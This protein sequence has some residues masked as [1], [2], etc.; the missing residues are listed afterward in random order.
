MLANFSQVKVSTDFDELVFFLGHVQEAARNFAELGDRLRTA[1]SRN[2]TPSILKHEINTVFAVQAGDLLCQCWRRGMLSVYR[3]H[4]YMLE[5]DEPRIRYVFSWFTFI[6]WHLAPMFKTRFRDDWKSEFA[7]EMDQ[8]KGQ[9]YHS[10][11][12]YQSVASD[13]ANDLVI[14][15]LNLHADV[16]ATACDI[17][18]EELGKL[19]LAVEQRLKQLPANPRK[20]TPNVESAD[21]GDT[22]GAR[23][24]QLP[25]QKLWDYAQKMWASGTDKFKICECISTGPGN[26]SECVEHLITNVKRTEQTR[27]FHSVK[28]TLNADIRTELGLEIHRV[29]EQVLLFKAGERPTLKRKRK[30]ATTKKKIG[31]K[32]KR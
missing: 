31:T 20:L 9:D 2:S 10:Q 27:R 1:T 18:A 30:S 12:D 8:L 26:Y 13:D 21:F 5:E 16:Q 14:W 17:V 24:S 11:R 15:R 29:G 22:G 23:P 32:R 25:Y 4:F 28:D 6:R 7:P 3:P 19:A